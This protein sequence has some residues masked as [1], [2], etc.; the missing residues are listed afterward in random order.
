MAKQEKIQ[1]SRGSI[2]LI[3]SDLIYEKEIAEL[4]SQLLNLIQLLTLREISVSNPYT[5]M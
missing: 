5:S 4:K 3:I 1:I 2:V